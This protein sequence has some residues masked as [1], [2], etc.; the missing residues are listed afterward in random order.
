MNNENEELEQG[1][2][3]EVL[4][5]SAH[6]PA[7]TDWKSVALRAQADYANL[8][9][10]IAADRAAM[11]VHALAEAVRGFLPV[12]EYFKRALQH[13]PPESEQ[14]PAVKNW[15]VG[16]MHIANLFKSALQQCGVEELVTIGKPFDPHTMDAVKEE[17]RDGT[18]PGTV[19]AEVESGYKLG[20]KIIKAARVVVAGESSPSSGEGPATPSDGVT[21]QQS[22][23]K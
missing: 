18:I 7:T 15:F 8:Q 10:T 20:D 23:N 2:G 22:Q 17:S 5:T 21:H 3:E 6:E 16:T 9:R 14:S 12:Y 19:I 1:A 13:V 11:G 4:E